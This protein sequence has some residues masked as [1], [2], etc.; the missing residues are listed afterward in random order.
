MLTSILLETILTIFAESEKRNVV[1]V[2]CKTVRVPQLFFKRLDQALIRF[3][4]QSTAPAGKMQVRPMS[5]GG[6]EFAAASDVDT[7]DETFLNQQVERP[8]DG[9]DVHGTG[10]GLDGLIDVLSA[11]VLAAVCHGLDDHLPLGGETVAAL[12]KAL[13][14]G[15]D[16]VHG[17]HLLLQI[18]ATENI[19]NNQ[20][21]GF[22]VPFVIDR[23]DVR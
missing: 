13:D 20:R 10:L 9:G 11:E 17:K 21:L 2:G 14:N 23:S 19:I 12:S 22:K 1:E 5:G 15:L 3:D 16:M 18:F 7:A 8:V 6:V 4:D